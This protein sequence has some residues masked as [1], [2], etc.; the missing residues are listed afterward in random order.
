MRS[1]LSLGFRIG[2]AWAS[3]LV[4]VLSSMPRSVGAETA[5]APP[6]DFGIAAERALLAQIDE[7]AR[8]RAAELEREI[9]VL[10]DVPA[11]HALM[12][13]VVDLKRVAWIQRLELQAA[14]ARHRGQ[15]ALAADA[16]RMLA[17]LKHPPEIPAAV[18]SLPQPADKAAAAAKLR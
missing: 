2:P 13:Q 9:A 16:E 1:V 4:F 18:R 7:A 6:A 12:K 8:K 14:Y 11:A 17:F 5:P 10:G 3:A 15:M